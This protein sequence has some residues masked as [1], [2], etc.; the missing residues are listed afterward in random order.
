MALCAQRPTGADVG[1]AAQGA[2]V[3]E[4]VIHQAHALLGCA[5][6]GL[7]A[8]GLSGVGSL[9][10]APL[11][12]HERGGG[13]S[14]AG[15][16]SDGGD[17]KGS[18][19]WEVYGRTTESP[20]ELNIV[21]GDVRKRFRDGPPSPCGGEPW[22]HPAPDGDGSESGSEWEGFAEWDRSAGRSSSGGGAESA[23]GGASGSQAGIEGQAHDRHRAAA[24]DPTTGGSGGGGG[25][26]GNLRKVESWTEDKFTAQPT[27]THFPPLSQ[28]NKLI[29][30][31][32][33]DLPEPAAD[34][35][36]AQ[37]NGV[38]GTVL[39]SNKG[40]SVDGGDGGAL[41]SIEAAAA[42]MRAVPDAVPAAVAE[43]A[44]AV[45]VL[46]AALDELSTNETAE[47]PTADGVDIST[48]AGEQ[49]GTFVHTADVASADSGSPSREELPDGGPACLVG[50][51]AQ[52][53][54]VRGDNGTRGACRQSTLERM[55]PLLLIHLDR[56]QP[57][58]NA[59][60]ALKDGSHVAFPFHMFIH[61]G[62]APAAGSACAQ[63]PVG[64][65]ARNSSRLGAGGSAARIG[66]VRY[67]LK[68][69]LVHEGRAVRD[70][71]YVCYAWRPS[72]VVKAAIVRT[73]WRPP[74]PAASSRP[75]A[76]PGSRQRSAGAS[77]RPS[78]A[79]PSRCE[80]HGHHPDD[81][82]S[83][84]PSASSCADGTSFGHSVSL[85]ASHSQASWLAPRHSGPYGRH[86]SA[87]GMQWGGKADGPE[88]WAGS[89]EDWD[90][91]FDTV[92]ALSQLGSRQTSRPGVGL[93]G[94]DVSGVSGSVGS[95][96]WATSVSLSDVEQEHR[97]VSQVVQEGAD[98]Q[99]T[100]TND[101]DA[102][103]VED[104]G[105]EL[106]VPELMALEE[107]NDEGVWVK[108]EE[109]TFEFVPWQVVAQ[110][111]AFMLMYEQV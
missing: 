50:P 35:A 66:A 21:E 25:S 99:R 103:A 20:A 60:S 1:D 75:I 49:S 59:R 51:T 109:A 26:V 88:G 85:S 62:V 12:L 18:R 7:D 36:A 47:R 91:G 96:G 65:A 6:D 97:A 3:V 87:G 78:S 57:R 86:A 37:L 104:P 70:G 83:S 107:M 14:S 63:P 108:C 11:T 9:F 94:G 13:D 52:G 48:P 79:G 69:V 32:F 4:R 43:E 84:L 34:V 105:S 31:T 61:P 98:G 19:G 67:R 80:R 73:A 76:V 55:P 92:G 82:A 89:P 23:S 53:I 110:S 100:A 101:G 8:V 2:A 27:R 30:A 46:A 22:L 68:A 28:R 64:A 106:S 81:A 38:D 5:A 71:H 56:Y 15:S 72:A 44:A 74:A 24:A 16:N 93:L 95:S 45:G 42:E 54:L 17:G 102:L 40:C 58:P 33:V 77:G 111:Q 10:S 39:A 29:A 41:P 90:E